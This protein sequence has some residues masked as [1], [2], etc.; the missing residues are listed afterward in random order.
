MSETDKRERLVWGAFLRSCEKFPDRPAIEVTG[1]Q[2]SYSE[3]GERARRLAATIQVN[4]RPVEVTLTA[5]FGYRSHTAYAAVLGALMSVHVY[6]LLNRSFPIDRTRV[7][8]EKSTCFSLVV[9]KE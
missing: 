3:L 4:A 2:L 5:V 6:V 7:M 8:L 9:D 1:S